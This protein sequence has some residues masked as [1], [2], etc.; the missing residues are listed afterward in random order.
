MTQELAIFNYEGADFKIAGEKCC[1]T[2]IEMNGKKYSAYDLLALAIQVANIGGHREAWKL[3]DAVKFM[4][5]FTN[6][7]SFKSLYVAT[8]VYL[9]TK[10]CVSEFD[11]HASFNASVKHLFGEDV[12]SVK[13]QY[14]AH[15][16]PDAW[17][18][19]EGKEI[20]VEM[21][22]YAFD[23]KACKQ[24]LRY[25]TFFKSG[26]GIAV[27]SKLTTP[28]PPSILFVSIQNIENKVYQKGVDF[29]RKKLSEMK[30]AA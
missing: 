17:L 19:I 21:K 11:I 30:K 22:K 27:G 26:V 25:M 14:D 3:M 4:D 20:P 1:Y 16:K 2:E 24:L 10:C 8:G 29:I 5:D 23:C 18:L 12:T 7:E 6:N 15:H 13:G 9:V 28:L